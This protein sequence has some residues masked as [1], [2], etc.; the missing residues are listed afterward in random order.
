MSMC[1]AGPGLT[2][3]EMGQEIGD[4]S[5]TLAISQMPPHDHTLR[6]TPNAANQQ[7]PSGHTLA[8][9]VGH[10]QY[11]DGPAAVNMRSDS[12]G[13]AGS[14]DSHSNVQPSTVVRFIIAI[15]GRNPRDE[16]RILR[17]VS[18]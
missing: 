7:V 13:T 18:D 14:G 10:S 11:Y 15:A 12:I 2:N 3:R 5:V 9:A 16:V 17:G 1:R 8:Q 6:G 4:E